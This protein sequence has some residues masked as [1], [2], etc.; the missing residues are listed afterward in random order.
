[1]T[2]IRDKGM[3]P[4]RAWDR[5]QGYHRFAQTGEEP[6]R[7]QL[8]QFEA[9]TGYGS[10]EVFYAADNARPEHRANPETWLAEGWYWWA[11]FPGCLPDGEP[12]GPY[13][14]SNAAYRAAQEGA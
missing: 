7:N 2:K 14:S 13:V 6:G 3:S 5:F 10:F 1:M 9:Q 11:C 12:E 8:G 4:R